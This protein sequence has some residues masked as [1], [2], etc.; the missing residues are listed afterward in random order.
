MAPPSVKTESAIAPSFL[1]LP[2]RRRIAYHASA[3]KGPGVIFMGGFKSDMTGSKAL[4]LEAFCQQQGRHF[5][6]FDY[7]GHGRSSGTFREGN[8]GRWTQ[9]ALDVIDRL[10]ARQ[11][12]L[13]GSSMGGW[14]MLLAALARPDKTCGLLGIAAAPD[15]TERL[16]WQQMTP[17]QQD[18]VMKAGEIAYPNCYGDEPYP[19]TRQLIEEGRNQ[20]LLDGPLRIDVPVRLIH[21]LQDQDVPWQTSITLS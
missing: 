16:M 17:Q 2:D 4:A 3:G 10:G 15:F 20:L 6:R 9:D 12:I 7:T 1:E 13:T 11:N 5:V 18:A 21:G 14:I 19:I 8:I